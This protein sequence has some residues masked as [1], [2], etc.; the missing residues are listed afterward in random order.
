MAGNLE[1]CRAPEQG[2]FDPQ[3]QAIGLWLAWD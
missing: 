2:L 3:S 1:G